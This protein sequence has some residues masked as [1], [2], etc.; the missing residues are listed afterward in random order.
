MQNLEKTEPFPKPGKVFCCNKCANRLTKKNNYLKAK[1]QFKCYVCGHIMDL[2]N[3][4]NN[5]VSIRPADFFSQKTRKK[6]IK[7]PKK[8][9]GQIQIINNKIQYENEI[10][11]VQKKTKRK[12]K[13]DDILDRKEILQKLHNHE[14]KKNIYKKNIYDI[15]NP[16]FIAFLFL[17][18]A[19]V[20]EII[21]VRQYS[22]ITKH[23]T[24]GKKL[25]D[26]TSK[27]LVEP[28]RKHQITKTRYAKRDIITWDV[29]KMPVL[30]K[31]GEFVIDDNK[32]LDQATKQ[33]I[34]RRHVALP[35]DF[36][37]D[38]IFFVDRWLNT[39][40]EDDIVF[41]FSGQNAWRICQLFDRTYNHLWR[42]LR[43]TDLVTTYGFDSLQL[44]HFFGWSTEAMARRYAHLNK[45]TLLDSMIIGYQNKGEKIE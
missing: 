23:G 43:A 11:Y 41:D 45:Y 24:K 20:E 7:K 29:E 21:G 1:Q 14:K 42:H 32:I 16:A 31:R 22:G 10:V 5:S 27:Y 19:R 28:I 40:K 25:G 38:F 34:P 26:W 39:L 33:I 44:R 6:I 12:F 4:D 3:S 35:Y 30:K 15:R 2:N 36:E 9:N 17:T 8:I 13:D 18:G 37:K